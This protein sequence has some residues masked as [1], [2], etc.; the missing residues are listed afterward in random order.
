VFAAGVVV[1]SFALALAGSASA[2]TGVLAWGEDEVGQLGNGTTL[3]SDTPVPASGLT[4]VTALAGGHRHS[5]ALLSDGTVMAWGEN[6][7]GQLGDSTHTG[8]DSCHATYASASDYTVACSTT[9]AP[10]GGLSGVVAIAAAAQDSYALLSNGTV[11]A[12]GDNEV[13]QLG[14][15]ST[16]GPEHCYKETEP[17]Q[18]STRP[19]AVRELSDVTAIAAGQ[20]YALALLSNGTVMSW[21][22]NGQGELGNGTSVSF[23]TLPT[24]VTGLDGVTAIAAN[25]DTSLA[26]GTGGTVMA[27]GQNTFG[28]LGDGGLAQSDVPV[29]VRGLRGVSAIAAGAEDGYALLSSGSVMAWGDAGVGQLGNGTERGSTEKGVRECFPGNFCSTAPVAVSALEHVTMIAAGSESGLALRSDGSVMAWGHNWGGQ[30]GDGSTETSDVPVLVSGLSQVTTIAAGSR[31]GLAYGT[32]SES[33][34]TKVAPKPK[35]LTRAEKL[36]KALKQ[37]KRKPKDKRAACERGARKKYAPPRK[38]NGRDLR[39]ARVLG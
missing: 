21:G 30:L 7:W 39:P 35:P 31:F 15:G 13:G 9:P 3:G 37:C 14:Q 2:S 22:S 11:M 19:V 25:F 10:V 26:L 29:A 18:C 34:P 6:D 12:W 32:L 23:T 17:T 27:W 8:P 24:A 5:L 38:Q 36:A 4:N 28:E 16:T 20:N 1:A 33:S